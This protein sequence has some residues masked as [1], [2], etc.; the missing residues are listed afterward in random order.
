M[1]HEGPLVHVVSFLLMATDSQV[2]KRTCMAK[3]AP[4]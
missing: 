1:T 4:L 3:S 2:K